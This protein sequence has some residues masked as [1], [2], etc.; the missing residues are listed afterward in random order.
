MEIKKSSFG[1]H[2]FFGII[3]SFLNQRTACGCHGGYDLLLNAS[4]PG[5]NNS[6]E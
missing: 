6:Q 3:F 2:D 5:V 1:K 4:Y